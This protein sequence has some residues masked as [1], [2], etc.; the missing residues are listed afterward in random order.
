[1][2]KPKPKK[3]TKK[4]GERTGIFFRKKPRRVVLG[5]MNLVGFTRGDG[6]C[7][8]PPHT[9]LRRYPKLPMGHHVRLVAEVL[10]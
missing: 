6:S 3:P 4:R 5:V 9:L 2:T 8:C 7:R 1:M 10:K